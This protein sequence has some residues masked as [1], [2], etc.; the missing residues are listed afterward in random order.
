M[1]QVITD[2]EEYLCIRWKSGRYGD[3]YV[4][5]HLSKD[6]GK[7]KLFDTEKEANGYCKLYIK[8]HYNKQP[9]FKVVAVV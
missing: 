9:N 7:A 3:T 2:K 4:E 1:F 5:T 8:Q 6:K